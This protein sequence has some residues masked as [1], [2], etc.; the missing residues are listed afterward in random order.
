MSEQQYVLLGCGPNGVGPWR[1]VF[2]GGPPPIVCVADQIISH[3][4]AIE[5][6]QPTAVRR[7]RRLHQPRLHPPQPNPMLHHHRRRPWISQ[8]LAHLAAG[9]VHPGP[10]QPTPHQPAHHR[11][12]D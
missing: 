11:F 1:R 8:Q 3:V 4:T 12:P 10:V 6:H 9:T 7:Q 5:N 2:S